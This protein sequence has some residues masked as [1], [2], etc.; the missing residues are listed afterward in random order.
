[1]RAFLAAT[2]AL[3]LLAGTG[4]FNAGQS[5][6]A[7][8][9]VQATNG[10]VLT[11]SAPAGD[12]VAFGVSSVSTTCTITDSLGTPV[13]IILTKNIAGNNDSYVFAYLSAGTASKT[14]TQAGPCNS[15]VTNT[16]VLAGANSTSAT[17][18]GTTAAGS[19]STLT[20]GTLNVPAGGF[21]MCVNTRAMSSATIGGN[22][23]TLVGTSFTAYYLSP[24]PLS[25]ASCVSNYTLASGTTLIYFALS[26]PTGSGGQLW[27]GAVSPELV[28]V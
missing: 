12:V 5:Y 16:Y 17:A 28:P 15:A 4:I 20:A 21:G 19:A 13:P 25:A 9:L 22:A 24:A 10:L 27:L 23:A 14:F 1:M 26:P 11:T 6:A 18:V 3:F 2:L 7:I 8:T